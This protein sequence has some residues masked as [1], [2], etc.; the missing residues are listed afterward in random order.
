MAQRHYNV[1]RM[2]NQDLQFEN[3]ALQNDL[4]QSR[5]D[6]TALLEAVKKVM[7]ECDQQRKQIA[8][9]EAANQRLCEMLW[10]R[11]SERRLPDKNQPL[12]PEAVDW[13]TKAEQEATRPVDALSD[14]EQAK[15]DAEIINAW[16]QRQANRATR[17]SGSQKLPDHL[18][19]RETVLD[20]TPEQKV[21]LKE[22]EQEV[23][24][25]LCLEKPVIYIRRTIRRRYV[26]L[27]EPE[28]GVIAP[29]PK[30]S[31]VPGCRYDFS[32][33]AA[34]I[35]MKFAFHQPTYRQ[36]DWLAQFGWFPN[37]STINDLINLGAATV[38]PLVGQ[39]RHLLLQQPYL[40]IDETRLR[41]LT[42]DALTDAQREQ[43]SRRKK[44]PSKTGK[45]RSD[46]CVNSYAWLFTG[47]PDFA[48]YNL[49]H[50]SLT[51]QQTTVDD[52][53]SDFHGTVIADAYDAYAHIAQRTTGRILHGSCNTHAQRRVHQGRDLRADL[54]LADDLVLSPA[55]YDRNAHRDRYRG[56]TL[57]NATTRSGTDL[58]T[59]G[60]VAEVDCRAGC[61][62]AE[63]P[64]WQGCGLSHKSM[65]RAAS[66]SDGRQLTDLER[67][68]RTNHSSADGGPSQLAIPGSSGCSAGPHESAHDCEQRTSPSSDARRVPGGCT[69]EAGRSQAAASARPGTQFTV[70][71]RLASRSL[72]RSSSRARATRSC[73]RESSSRRA[74]QVRR[75]LRRQ[76][77]REAKEEAATA[78][79]VAAAAAATNPVDPPAA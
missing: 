44:S 70:S 1:T 18:E 24:D 65:G 19:V 38:E 37:R 8:E 53:L 62:V 58:A 74:Q 35:G 68:S 51:R 49:F 9:L 13:F 39:V 23:T 2:S 29:L 21:G 48:P 56:T 4:N 69:Y 5:S 60:T 64:V 36:Q 26:A 7:A 52:I 16:K 40:L 73:R 30:L 22:L 34:V 47:L 27:G 32:V 46:G 66:L 25:Q 11:R 79:A 28:R 78:A 12:L 63:Q 43:L 45:P 33:I 61:G 41:L 31:I 42:R 50:W 10:G 6:Y 55:V 75:A 3:N 14:E 20:L 76:Q 71:A 67:S 77:A 59:H 17:R 57:G 54:G 15:L 72:G